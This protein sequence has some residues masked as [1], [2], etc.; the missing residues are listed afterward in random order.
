V[1]D[2]IRTI[3]ELEVSQLGDCIYI[4]IKARSFLWH[5]VRRIVSAG[6]NY[7]TGSIDG[8]QLELALNK[9]NE[10]IDFGLAPAEP[11][12]LMEVEY[13]FKFETDDQLLNRTKKQLM[14]RWNE[15]KIQESFT[16]YLMN[17][18]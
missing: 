11:L 8:E 3:D 2:A 17:T 14:G 4:D 10:S 6:I 15:I 12:F 5:Q 7:A 18:I 13:D 16:E 9:P 1:E